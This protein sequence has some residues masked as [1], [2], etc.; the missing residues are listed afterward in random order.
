MPVKPERRKKQM[1]ESLRN[2][3][4]PNCDVAEELSLTDRTWVKCQACGR[5]WMSVHAFMRAQWGAGMRRAKEK[6]APAAKPAVLRPKVAAKTN[7][8]AHVIQY[9]ENEE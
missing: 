7:K 1:V 6:K 5:E 2:I 3:E 4:C 8:I 9:K